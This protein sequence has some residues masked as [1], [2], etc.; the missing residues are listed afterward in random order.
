MDKDIAFLVNLL[1]VPSLTVMNM[2]VLEK[3]VFSDVKFPTTETMTTTR[4]MKIILFI[5][6]WLP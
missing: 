4:Q 3:V 2:P 5:H 6:F 1:R